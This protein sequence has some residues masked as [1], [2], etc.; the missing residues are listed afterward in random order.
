[1]NNACT[2][3]V[4][5]CCFVVLP[6]R[7][8]DLQPGKEYPPAG[9]AEAIDKLR[10][11]V[12]A[13]H[14]A[15]RPAERGQHPKHQGCVWA[16]FVVAEDLPATVKAG[17]F[18]QPAAYT[19]LIRF[20]NGDRKDDR[21]P[22][23]HGMAIKLFDVEG[24][25]VLE[26]EKNEKTHDFILIDHPVFFLKDVQN[27][28]EFLEALGQLGK[29]KLSPADTQK[30]LIKRFPALDG[31]RKNEV[32]SPL[33]SPYWSQTPYRLGT[34]AAK[35]LVRPASQNGTRKPA[36]DT[37][38][39]RREAL[40]EH[41]TMNKNEARF[42]FFVQLQTDARKMPIED[43]T[44]HWDEDYS[45]PIKVAT[46][47]IAPQKFDSPE[48]QKFCENLSFT[49]WHCLPEHR[50]LGGVNR[51]RWRVYEDSAKLRHETNRA[52]RQ[53]PTGKE[54]FE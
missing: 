46:I 33:E 43:A 47:T 16:K 45:K 51:A 13:D 15:T 36:G 28:L 9:E 48:Q 25:K 54:R 24:E 53:E 27:V 21:E 1:M 37:V 41:L 52:P 17:L 20:S 49:V 38:D 22:D 30:E 39:F 40:A 3:T 23:G 34:H 32:A 12:S 42:D 19:A 35:Y 2:L 7:A 5:F 11:L 44:V 29:Q 26:A 50:P 4:V 6:S 8:E 18:K 14:K 31:F 10:Q